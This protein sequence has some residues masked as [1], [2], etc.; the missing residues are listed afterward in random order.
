MM[1]VQAECETCHGEG[2]IIKNKCAK[3]NGEGVVRDEEIITINIPAGAAAG[4]ISI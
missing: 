4:G 3:C 2:Q 1:Q